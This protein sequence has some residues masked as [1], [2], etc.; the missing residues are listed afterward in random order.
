MPP[1]KSSKANVASCSSCSL[2]SNSAAAAKA[3]AEA[4][5]S[6]A[7]APEAP[8]A[9]SPA[10]AADTLIPTLALDQLHDSLW[11]QLD[12]EDKRAL[13]LVSKAMRAEVDACV[14]RLDV[15]VPTPAHAHG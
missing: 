4:Q 10:G 5:P 13:R 15:D 7:A 2:R 6:D 12:R 3:A 11:A 14:R 1:R 9:Q 8:Q